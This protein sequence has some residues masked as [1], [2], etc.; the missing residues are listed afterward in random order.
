MSARISW[1]DVKLG[2][3][4]TIKHPV[5]SLVGGLGIAV[6]I[7]V[8][9][10]FFSF[11]GTYIY[12]KLPLDEGDRVVA[13]ENRDIAINDEERRS[14]HDFFAWREQLRSVRDLTAFR[15]V[16]RNLITGDGAP[17]PVQ[18]AEMTAA[19]FRL[20]RVPALL[21][22]HLTDDDERDGAPPVL[23]IGY[24]I[25]QNRFAADPNIIARE[26]RLG[27]VPH[28]VIGV[29]PEGFAFP[30]SH[31]YWTAFRVRPS[32]Y[33]RREGPAI[34]I[35]GRLAPG[36]TMA[37]AQGELSA[38]GRRASAAFPETHEQL[39]P[40]VMPYTHTLSGV[41]GI[42]LWEVLSMNLMM[43]I[44]LAVVVLNVAV[45]VY[46]RTA[47]RHGEIATRHALGA[48]R[49]RIVA[50]LFAEALVLSLAA[51]ALGMGLARIGVEL[52]DRIMALEMDYGTP[53]WIDYSVRPS[54]VLFAVA[55]AVLTAVVTGVLPALQATRRN[56]QADLRQIGQGGAR[57]GRTWTTL[58]VAQ[59]AIAVIGL[60]AATNIGWSGMRGAFTQRIYPA[61]EFLRATVVPETPA[62]EAEGATGEPNVLFAVRL[63]ELMGRLRARPDVAGLTF[64]S[65]T[66]GHSGPILVEGERPP[67]DSPGGH[68][69]GAM[70][71]YPGYDAVFG[72]RVLRGRPLDLRDLGEAS[73]VVMVSE[74]FVRDV[75]GG[76]EAV[77]RR[78]RHVSQRELAGEDVPVEWNT[79]VGV[80]Q[81]LVVNRVA[82]DVI[83]P[84]LYY[85]VRPSNIAAAS[86][87]LRLRGTTPGDFSPVLRQIAA[88][89]DPSLRV[90][91]IRSMADADQQLQLGARLAGLAV[92]LVLLIGLLL[93]AAGIYAM[94]SF[95]ITQRRREI[96]IRSALGGQPRQVVLAVFSRAASQ[97]GIGLGVGVAAAVGIEQLTDGGLVGGRGA[98]LLPA[99]AV[100]M[101]V[102]GLLAALGP[103]R[104]GLRIEPTEA[105]RAEG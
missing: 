32:A 78:I 44:V 12:P 77:G 1:L 43:G 75:L 72:A 33:E 93:S 67:I 103:A 57:L 50:Q 61:E 104:R 90:A 39:R 64:N 15:T 82:P 95:T 23:V 16:Q 84:V 13:L 96:G 18:V 20:A 66:A 68:G 14:V 101:A 100:I 9:V 74:S 105:L 94:M 79:I 86:L 85:P 71:V 51:A 92:G 3:R 26:V 91:G 54:T 7:A 87:I 37:T 102:V 22:R 42:T 40:M 36:V 6:G 83:G 41:H 98:V 99:I 65:S 25:W 35:A 11:T 5:L 29:M 76:G 46:A 31:R 56:V 45:L 63:T 58:I 30:E 55:L 62:A 69:V 21:G 48:S 10:A 38:I 53:F 70:G 52:T 49:G 2:L 59:V 8:S 27:G 88:D 81:D 80:V 28:T 34:F 4:M 47:A 97:I 73:R 89:V 24:H 17:E 19:G 60:P